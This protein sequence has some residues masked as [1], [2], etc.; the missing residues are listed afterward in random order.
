MLQWISSLFHPGRLD[1]HTNECTWTEITR[2]RVP[3]KTFRK[4][5]PDSRQMRFEPG[6]PPGTVNSKSPQRPYHFDQEGQ[7]ESL[8]N[9]KIISKTNCSTLQA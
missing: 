5:F 7:E 6:L 4:N 2:N 3:V 1:I 8:Y 9:S